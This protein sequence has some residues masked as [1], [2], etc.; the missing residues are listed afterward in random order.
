MNEWWEVW[1]DFG[2]NGEDTVL[3]RIHSTLIGAQY[4][5]NP[6]NGV[7]PES[8]LNRLIHVVMSTIDIPGVGTVSSMTRADLPLI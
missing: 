1:A 8:P 3:F 7:L 6:D 5:L 4:D 2:L